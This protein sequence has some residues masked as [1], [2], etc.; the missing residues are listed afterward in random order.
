M[1]DFPYK[2]I[3]KK[4]NYAFKD[5]KLLKNAFVH[6][7]YANETGLPDNER[8]EFFGDAILETIS[9]E[10]LYQKYPDKDAGELSKARSYIVSATGLK[11]V[12]AELGIM[13]YLLVSGAATGLKKLSKKIEANLYEAVLCAVYLDGGMD[14]AKRFVLT[15]LTKYMD[16]VDHVVEP[17]YKSLLQEYCQQRKMTIEYVRTGR[18]GPDNQPVFTYAL[19][20]DGELAAEGTG[21]S[22]KNA[23]AEAAKKIVR[24][25]GIK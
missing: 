14:A 12:V 8:M 15:T 19:Y 6:S 4:L 21:S 2:E 16:N 11:P 18:S 20:I 25:W 10:Y 9:S 17:D 22:I 7:S 13:K 24:E 23:E 1:A 5:R 3:E